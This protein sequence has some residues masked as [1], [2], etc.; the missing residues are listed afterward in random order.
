MKKIIYTGLLFLFVSGSI[1]SLD[2]GDTVKDLPLKDANDAPAKIPDLGQKT[3]AIFYTDPDVKDQND[4]FADYLKAANLPKATYRGMGIV[5]LKDTWLPNGLL[6]SLIR[7]KIKK[8][9]TTIL[10]DPARILATNWGLG[11]CDDKSVVIVIDKNKKVLYTHKGAVPSSEFQKV[12][13]IIKKS[14]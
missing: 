11:S 9:N 4:P 7:D 6:R 14:L 5:N 1:F 8:Y 2:I 12:L 13:D 10:T 3:L